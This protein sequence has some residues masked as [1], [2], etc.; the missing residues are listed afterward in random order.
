MKR[1]ADA[2]RTGPA[3]PPPSCRGGWVGGG[4]RRLRRGWTCLLR[5]R[6]LSLGLGRIQSCLSPSHT[7]RT[8]HTRAPH[9]CPT[10]DCLQCPWCR[11]RCPG[12]GPAAADRVQDVSRRQKA[13]RPFSCPPQARSM[14]TGVQ[15]APL[16]QPSFLAHSCPTPW[17][18][19]FA[20]GYGAAMALSQPFFS[21]FLPTHLLCRL[22]ALHVRYPP[23]T[24]VAVGVGR[25]AVHRQ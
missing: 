24:R 17:G 8:T 14:P 20:S 2:S 11:R 15:R 21:L 12:P 4:G 22:I 18:C 9:P 1:T 23:S 19:R 25:S 3:C 6:S 16:R 7:L 10:D 13:A 5:R